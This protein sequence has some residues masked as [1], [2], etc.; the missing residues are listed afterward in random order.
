MRYS[1]VFH[2]VDLQCVLNGEDIKDNLVLK[3]KEADISNITDDSGSTTYIYDELDQMIRENNHILNKTITYRY[4]AGGNLT[5]RKEYAKT[6]AVSILGASQKT[7]IYTY[8]S[9]W[10]D[11]LIAING[12]KLTYDSIGNLLSYDGAAYHWSVGRQLSAVKNGKTIFYSYDHTGMRI[13]KEVNGVVT[14][15]HTAGTLI[16][17]ETTNGSTI[18]YNYDSKCHL[19]SIVYNHTDYFY[20]T[21]LQEDIIALIDKT[22]NKVV[23]YKYDSWGAIVSVTGSMAETLGMKNPF[24][25]RGYYYDEETGMY[26]ISNRYYSPTI[27]RFINTDDIRILDGGNDHI[28]EN[29]LWAYCFNS[30]VNMIDLYGAWGVP[31]FSMFG[32]TAGGAAATTGTVG[33]TNIWNPIGWLLIG[34]A[35]TVTIGAAIESLGNITISKGRKQ[36][37]RDTGFQGLSNEEVWDI[38]NH[39][40]SPEE[41]KRAEG[42]LKA[43]G[44][45]N[46]QKKKSQ[47]KHSEGKLKKPKKGKLNGNE[48]VK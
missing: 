23:E 1:D 41:S 36:N 42:E 14:N 34:A 9:I 12:K 13:K 40:E 26:Y 7:D 37:V 39:S 22:E 35:A 27:R 25:Y 4:D 48:R 19:I 29:N 47:Y 16:T 21:N 38:Y 10:K 15:Y 28:F 24:R 8:D 6:E 20:V 46:Q 17:G 32:I 2:D 43:R 3:S 11:K 30:S 31:L 18:W 33:L 5:E 44:E 45:K